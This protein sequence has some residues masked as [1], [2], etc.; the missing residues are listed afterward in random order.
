MAWIT[1][2]IRGT[3]RRSVKNITTYYHTQVGLLLRG[4]WVYVSF[5]SI[6]LEV[7]LGSFWSSTLLIHRFSQSTVI[8]GE[9]EPPRDAKGLFAP[10]WSLSASSQARRVERESPQLAVSPTQEATAATA[11]TDP[12]RFEARLCNPLFRQVI[13]R[14]RHGIVHVILKRH[15]ISMCTECIDVWFFFPTKDWPRQKTW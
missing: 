15:G 6:H 3:L 10:V 13:R 9:R 12:N 4:Y 14:Q 7:I 11:A 8:L 1:S 2:Q 5:F